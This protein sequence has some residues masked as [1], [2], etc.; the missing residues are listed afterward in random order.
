MPEGSVRDRAEKRFEQM[1]TVEK[2]SEEDILVKRKEITENVDIM[3]NNFM[4]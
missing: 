1:K 3:V 4:K 2:E